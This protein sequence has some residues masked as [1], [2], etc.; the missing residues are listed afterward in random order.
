MASVAG[1]IA[2]ICGVFVYTYFAENADVRLS[3]DG[4]WEA[5][6]VVAWSRDAS[7]I[8]A[9]G[10]PAGGSED[11][12]SAVVWSAHTGRV[13]F[14]PAQGKGNVEAIAIAPDN[15]NVAYI[16]SENGAVDVRKLVTAR[17]PQGEVES[18]DTLHCGFVSSLMYSP[19]GSRIA[20]ISDRILIWDT[21]QRKVSDSLDIERICFVFSARF[22]AENRLLVTC[23][24]NDTLFIQEVG[25]GRTHAFPVPASPIAGMPV[26]SPNGMYL[27]YATVNTLFV[28]STTE[29]EPFSS[30]PALSHEQRLLSVSNDGSGVLLYDTIGTV[31]FISRTSGRS[32]TAAKGN[33]V[34]LREAVA[35]A[36]GPGSIASS[37]DGRQV[38]VPQPDKGLLLL[39]DASTGKKIAEIHHRESVFHG[40]EFYTFQFTPDGSCTTMRKRIHVWKRY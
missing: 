33:R 10:T 2:V 29:F 31:F 24:S 21:D 34:V 18:E 20:V 28:R 7:I 40:P 22:V 39:F 25:P 37:P 15:R 1:F 35:A 16:V 4:G 13:L 26:F 3:L 12:S 27:A 19:K 6:H 30:F 14:R 38:A 17:L 32:D 23:V 8:A 36:G 5:V 9:V 11:A